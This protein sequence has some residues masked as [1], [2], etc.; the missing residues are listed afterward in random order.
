MDTH[1]FAVVVK[2]PHYCPD[3][4]AFQCNVSYVASRHLT[5]AEA[6]QAAEKIF[7]D[8]FGD[9]SATVV[10]KPYQEGEDTPLVPQYSVL[11]LYNHDRAWE[12]ERHLFC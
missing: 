3:T 7:E 10:I 1:A 5:K 9:V 11:E 2:A 12:H 8:T 6:D 4:D